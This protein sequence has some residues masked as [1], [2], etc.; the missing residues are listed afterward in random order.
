MTPRQL[1]ALVTQH[2][3]FNTGDAPEA[4]HATPRPSQ[5]QGSAGWLMA[6]AADLN[7]RKAGVG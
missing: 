1:L 7:S 3:I 5:K 4:V 6:V 2:R